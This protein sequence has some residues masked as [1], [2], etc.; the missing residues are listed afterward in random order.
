MPSSS[1]PHGTRVYHR[2]SKRT[3]SAGGARTL[4]IAGKVQ[5][6][7]LSAGVSDFDDKA[8]AALNYANGKRSVSHIARLVSGELDDLPVAQTVAWF[9]LLAQNGVIE[10]SQE[11]VAAPAREAR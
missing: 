7:A 11:A 10:W 3:H 9:E 5:W 1:L 6:D 2:N 8:I 4:P